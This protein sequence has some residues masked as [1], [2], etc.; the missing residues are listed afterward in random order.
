MEQDRIWENYQNN[1][2]LTEIG[3]R[4][5]GRIEAVAR[6]IPDRSR[7]LNIGVGRGTLENI[8]TS[9]N[10]EVYCLDPSKTSIE[11]LRMSLGLGDRAQVGYSQNIPFSDCFFDYVVMTEVLEHLSE[12][13]FRKSCVEVSRVLKS[14][15]T[16]LGTV[17]ADEDLKI[18]MVVCPACGKTFHRWGHVQSFSLSSLKLLLSGYFSKVS[19]DRKVFIEWRA[20]NWKGKI[21]SIFRLVLVKLGSQGSNQNFIFIAKK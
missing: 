2:E 1:P 14:D 19:I 3:C 7:V 16:F 10:I 6:L 12:D 20:L 5:G 18:S 8:L 15:G 9:R 4:D 13:V 17:P 21:S 11:R